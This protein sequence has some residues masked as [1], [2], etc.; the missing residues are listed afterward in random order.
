MKTVTDYVMYKVVSYGKDAADINH[1]E[2]LLK[3]L[4]IT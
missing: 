1:N 3:T 4:I 2:D